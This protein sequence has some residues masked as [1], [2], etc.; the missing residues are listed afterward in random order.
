MKLNNKGFA[1]STIMYMILI[2][3]VILI[4]LTLTL[5]SS[6]KLILDKTKEE[7]KN[8]IYE[9]GRLPS[10]YQEVEY[11][12]ST[13]TQYIG[14]FYTVPETYTTIEFETK[15]NTSSSLEQGIIGVDKILEIGYS[16][17]ANR[18]ILWD[19]NSESLEYI[20]QES[21][22]NNDVVIKITLNQG[23]S[24]TLYTSLDGGKT[25]TQDINYTQ[26]NNKNLDLLLY[27][28]NKQDYY[29]VGKMYYTRIKIDGK[30]VRDMIP[31]YRK[32]N[33]AIGMYD[34]VNDVFY[35]N[36]GTGTFTKG[37]DVK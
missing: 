13:G 15:T 14:D 17:V 8:N 20:S 37:N 36:S 26:I 27:N 7:A 11:I 30:L 33:N 18:I 16:S 34:L 5:L 28:G 22:R 23:T 21:A 3:A 10:G 2:M 12:T 32:T 29:F 25:V 35:T 9:S 1:V 24:K 6:R 19:S 4:T 31:C